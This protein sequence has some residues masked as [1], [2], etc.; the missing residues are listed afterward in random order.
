MRWARYSKKP[1]DPLDELPHLN[2]SRCLV[3]GPDWNAQRHA[4]EQ[5]ATADCRPPVGDNR[6]IVVV[7]P[8]DSRSQSG[9][10]FITLGKLLS[11]KEFALKKEQK[12]K[13][14]D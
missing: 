6:S 10:R 8:K 3:D 9:N 1:I 2:G 14:D 5:L 13:S 4:P 7:T 11:A 12:L